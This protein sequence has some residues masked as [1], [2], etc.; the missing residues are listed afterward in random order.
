MGG[1]MT[2]KIS[3]IIPVY[4][5]EEYISACLSQILKQTYTDFEVIIIDDG[6]TDKSLEQCKKVAL[7]DSRLRI[8]SQENGGVS[9]ARNTGIIN[10][11]GEIITFV[12]S[13]DIVAP[14]YL[15]L[16]LQGI[17][18]SDIVLSMCS[19]TRIHEYNYKFSYNGGGFIEIPAMECAKRL[20]NEQF[21]VSVCGVLFK[22][23]LVG[24][25][26]F[27]VGISN[28][29]D[30][31]FLYEY[32]LKNEQKK[33]LFSN[34]KLYG[35]MVRNGS[36]TRSSWNGSM[37]IVKVA[38]QI[39][40]L[41]KGYHPEWRELAKNTCMKARLSTMKYIVLSKNKNDYLHV[42]EKLRKDV[43]AMEYPKSGNRRLKIEYLA[44]KFGRTCFTLLVYIYYRIT[45][46]KKRFK[47][48]EKIT[49]QRKK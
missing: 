28:N 49:Y 24:N 30:K 45:S 48:N 3:I 21:P 37:D 39:K 38:D 19:C 2:P 25:I 27:S 11:Q 43:L 6:S 7:S 17:A 15:L 44:A 46:D 9:S 16:L 4:N 5:A 29:E 33:V 20:L 14:N 18:A 31:L 47:H 36:A 26:R 10:A 12:D 13:D 35:Y 32:L 1:K 41:T 40:R 34:E 23:Q 8:I 42:Y 22:K